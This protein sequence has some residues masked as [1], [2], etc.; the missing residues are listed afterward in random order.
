M[1]LTSKQIQRLKDTVAQ[2][3][4]KTPA[5]GSLAHALTTGAVE[6]ATTSTWKPQKPT[7][8]KS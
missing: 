6:G 2:H 7:R 8:M 4:G 3:F 1:R 5:F